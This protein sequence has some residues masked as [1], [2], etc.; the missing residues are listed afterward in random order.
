MAEAGRR[1]PSC[2]KPGGA[3][4]V[5]TNLTLPATTP[6]PIRCLRPVLRHLITVWLQVRVLPG[7][8][9]K[10]EAYSILFGITAPETHRLVYACHAL[11]TAKLSPLCV[12]NQA[13]RHSIAD[14]AGSSHETVGSAFRCNHAP[15]RFHQHLVTPVEGLGRGELA[16]IVAQSALTWDKD[17][18]RRHTFLD[19]QCVVTRDGL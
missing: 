3:A 14:S 5:R 8:P 15:Q 17:Q 16:R 10:S 12:P 2:E 18:G 19:R 7:P 6:A 13:V 11:A 1:R 9:K 4:T